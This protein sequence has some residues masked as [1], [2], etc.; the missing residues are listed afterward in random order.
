[1]KYLH[2]S[3]CSG[4]KSIYYKGSGVLPRESLPTEVSVGTCFLINWRPQIKLSEN[5]NKFI[6]ITYIIKLII[7]IEL[8]VG[9]VIV[10]AVDFLEIY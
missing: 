4:Y 2:Y 6:F 9:C 5:K 8:Y 7:P 10:Y 3:K 1:M